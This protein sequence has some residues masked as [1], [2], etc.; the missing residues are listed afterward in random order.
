MASNLIWSFVCNKSGSHDSVSA[1]R[2]HLQEVELAK[3]AFLT[4]FQAVLRH[5]SPRHSSAPGR[6]SAKHP[7]T[8]PFLLKLSS[9]LNP[10]TIIFS[11]PS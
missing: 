2:S 4:P 9:P 6:G 1:E 10:L 3:D 11:N 7:V 5:R 8:L